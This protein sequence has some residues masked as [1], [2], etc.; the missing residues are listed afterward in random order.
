MTNNEH[1]FHSKKTP[2]RLLSDELINQ[3]RDMMEKLVELRES[4]HLSVGDV[5][6][7]MG[8]DE[9]YILDFE[10]YSADPHLDDIVSYALAV[11]AR[12]SIEVTDGE[13]WAKRALSPSENQ[14]ISTWVTSHVPS[15]GSPLEQYVRTPAAY[16]TH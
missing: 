7:L 3:T 1:V 16:V 13:A 11:K 6:D 5:A 2:L 10:S 8:V 12:L 14:V 9:D 15:T 4:Q